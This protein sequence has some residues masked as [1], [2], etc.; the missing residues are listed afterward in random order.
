[1]HKKTISVLRDTRWLVRSLETPVGWRLRRSYQSSVLTHHELLQELRAVEPR[2]PL[3]G[4]HCCH[5]LVERV[6]LQNIM[7]GLENGRFER[8]VAPLKI[9]ILLKPTT[10]S[11]SKPLGMSCCR[12]A[13][14]CLGVGSR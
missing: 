7:V 10:T 13:R 9:R 14:E 8:K 6:H 1:M 4:E 12:C 11:T 2:L 3:V 5:C